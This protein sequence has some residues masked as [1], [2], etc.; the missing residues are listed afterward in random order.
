MEAKRFGKSWHFKHVRGDRMPG[1]K[2]RLLDSTGKPIAK[3]YVAEWHIK[4][5]K[6]DADAARKLVKGDGLKVVGEVIELDTNNE[7]APGGWVHYLQIKLTSLSNWLFTPVA[8]N[9]LSVRPGTFTDDDPDAVDTL[10]V[11]L[12]VIWNEQTGEAT[13]IENTTGQELENTNGQNLFNI[14]Q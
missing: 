10:T 6:Q 4:K 3:D 9:W 5:Y 7:E 1:Y 14:P 8:G 12:P 13:P 11:R 2:V